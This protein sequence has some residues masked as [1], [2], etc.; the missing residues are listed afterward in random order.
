MKTQTRYAK[1]P[2]GSLTTG[3]MPCPCC[4]E[5]MPLSFARVF[6]GLPFWCGACGVK[7]QADLGTGE[8]AQQ[9]LDR[10]KEVLNTANRAAK[11]R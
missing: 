6:G 2:L 7:I 1:D 4:G 9:T 3:A 5:S 10:A 11:Q 8:Q